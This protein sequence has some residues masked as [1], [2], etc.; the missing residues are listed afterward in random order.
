MTNFNPTGI[1]EDFERGN[2]QTI[3]G[4]T[5]AMN[6]YAKRGFISFIPLP[7][8]QCD[9]DFIAYHPI[10]HE[11]IKVQAKTSAYSRNG[12][13]IIPLKSGGHGKGNRSV[14]KDYDELFALNALGETQVIPYKDIAD[15]S[16]QVTMKK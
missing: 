1:F 14:A 11:L 6:H 4:V 8:A 16:T 13:H 9:I 3:L 2:Q 10:T 5:E 15:R 7:D 12:K